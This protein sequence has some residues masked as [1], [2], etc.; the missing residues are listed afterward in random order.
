MNLAKIKHNEPEYE[1]SHDKTPEPIPNTITQSSHTFTI[2]HNQVFWKA[3]AT[4]RDTTG[5]KNIIIHVTRIFT[6]N[7]N[8][9]RKGITY[10]ITVKLSSTGSAGRWYCLLFGSWKYNGLIG[11]NSYAVHTVTGSFLRSY[12]NEHNNMT[13]II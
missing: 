3:D 7:S 2:I 10:I 11:Q 1:P 9:R 13:V 8:N 5:N 4:G 6:N 12:P